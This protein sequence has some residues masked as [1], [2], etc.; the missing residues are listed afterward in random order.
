MAYSAKQSF[1]LQVFL[2]T[3]AGT[4]PTPAFLT[5]GASNAIVDFTAVQ[6]GVGGNSITVALV[7]PGTGT[8]TL[9]V[10]VTGSAIVV[11]LGYASSAITSTANDVISAILASPEASAL[12]IPSNGAGTGV[13]L[14]SAVS[15]TALATGSNGTA[16]YS[17]I[18]GVGDMEIPGMGR[19]SDDITSHSSVD[20]YAEY[21]KSKV[22]DG[23]SITIPINY[24]PTNVVHQQLKLAEASDGA[25]RFRFVYPHA[26]G[27][28]E[29][30]GHVLNFS[31]SSPV[32]GV[33]TGSIE[34]QLTG[35]PLAID[36]A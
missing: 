32:R 33:F 8:A 18:E 10:V 11:N 4:D 22:K 17:E 27:D 14:V 21:L 29:N 12:V 3:T 34:V 23:R 1:G 35:A 26:G 9:G 30:D 15:A 13:S 5:T 28:F 31:T 7:S 20:G 2:E 6:A 16:V 25:S 24:D 36:L 19:T